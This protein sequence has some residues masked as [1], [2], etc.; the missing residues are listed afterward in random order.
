MMNNPRMGI[1][2]AAL[3]LAIVA[4]L[5]LYIHDSEAEEMMP[6]VDDMNMTIHPDPGIREEQFKTQRLFERN[7]ML[8]SEYARLTREQNQLPKFIPPPNGRLT[9]S[10]IERYIGAYTKFSRDLDHFNKRIVGERPGF[11]RVVALY[12]MIHPLF[13]VS[14]MSAQTAYDFTAE[15]FDWVRQRIFKA[16]LFCVQY[17]LDNESL[18]VNE[19]KRLLDLRGRLYLVTEV[20]EFRS[21]EEDIFHQDRLRLNEVPRHNLRLFLDNYERI[22]YSEVNFM[23]PSRIYFDRD[24]IMRAASSNPP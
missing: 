22:R 20:V 3:W 7:R 1:A 8:D 17:K 23:S 12:G 15:E 2:F 5:G 11:L 6:E 18:T 16:A 19:E 13:T 14:R 24:A 9:E 21:D 10:Q 4:G